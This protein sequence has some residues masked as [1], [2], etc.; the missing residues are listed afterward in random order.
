MAPGVERSARA[1]SIWLIRDGLSANHGLLH[2]VQTR[3]LIVA[4]WQLKEKLLH[5]QGQAA[6]RTVLALLNE[7]VGKDSYWP[8]RRNNG[9]YHS[10][11]LKA[12]WR[13][14]CQVLQGPGAREAQSSGRQTPLQKDAPAIPACKVG[15]IRSTRLPTFHKDPLSVFPAVHTILSHTL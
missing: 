1:S 15:P 10:T 4:N 6:R 7:Y 14:K 13:R 3:Q 11:R 5:T 8:G 2:L 9:G 12:K